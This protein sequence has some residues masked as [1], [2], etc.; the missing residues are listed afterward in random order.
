[1]E[2]IKER[3]LQLFGTSVKYMIQDWWRLL[4]MSWRKTADGVGG[5][6]EDWL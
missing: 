5:Q 1:M 4:C 2:V 3:K 6:W